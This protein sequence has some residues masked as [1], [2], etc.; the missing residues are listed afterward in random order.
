[1][2]TWYVLD[3]NGKPIKTQTFEEGAMWSENSMNS[4]TRQIAETK[5]DDVSISTVFLCLD[6]NFSG[7]GPPLLYETLVFNGALD[8]EM[9]RYPTEE[10]AL[11][12]HQRMVSLVVE[13]TRA[14]ED[15]LKNRQKIEKAIPRP[16]RPTSGRIIDLDL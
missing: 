12:G 8:G 1:M 15:A 10:D 4:G 16:T 11:E 9:Y 6:H 2:S 7:E 3:D 13:Q 14:E 5:I